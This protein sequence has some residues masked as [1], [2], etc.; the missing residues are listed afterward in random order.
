MDLIE[1]HF[2]YTQA[3]VV[4]PASASTS[5][6]QIPIASD[7]PFVLRSIGGNNFAFLAG[8]SIRFADASGRYRQANNVGRNMFQTS[9]IGGLFAPI[10]PQIVYPPTSN[11]EFIIKNF[12]NTPRTVTPYFRGITLHTPGSVYAPPFPANFELLP[13]DYPLEVA[14]V[15]GAATVLLPDQNLFIKADADFLFTHAQ[16]NCDVS[17]GVGGYT[18]L[19]VKIKDRLGKFYSSDFI[20]INAYLGNNEGIAEEPSILYPGIYLKANDF[21][22]FDFQLND[23]VAPGVT[24][25]FE[26][27]CKGFKV[28]PK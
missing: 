4:V 1:R 23:T 3:N 25:F 11:L 17:R 27:L 8:L 5:N 20:D 15:E 28:F 26:L 6:L 12:T 24:L 10:Y 7:A 16:V 2:T 13:F 21:L 18:D 19:R 22:A 14:I 9:L